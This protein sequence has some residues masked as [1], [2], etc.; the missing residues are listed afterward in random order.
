MVVSCSNEETIFNQQERDYNVE[1]QLR[2]PEEALAIAEEAQQLFGFDSRTNKSVSISDICI[3][4]CMNMSK[5][6][7]N[8][9]AIYAVNFGDD[10]GFALIAASRACEKPL[11]GITDS[12]NYPSATEPMNNFSYFLNSARTYAITPTPKDSIIYGDQGLY[13]V[14][15]LIPITTSVF[16]TINLGQNWPENMYCPNK[17][18]GCA[19]VAIAEMLSFFE[20]LNS[21]SLTY[22]NRD[23]DSIIIDWENLKV[24]RMS[25]DLKNPTDAQIREH[26][27]GCDASLDDH[28]TIG[29]FIRQLGEIQ[30]SRYL[31]DI[32][33]TGTS[34]YFDAAKDLVKSDLICTDGTG[35]RSLHDRFIAKGKT[36]P[37]IALL[38]GQSNEGGHGWIADGYSY[39][40]KRIEYFRK[41]TN[42]LVLVV[43]KID[44]YLHFNW[45]WAGK[46]NG[47]FL[48]DALNPSKEYD[49]WYR[50]IENGAPDYEYSTGVEYLFIEK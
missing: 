15:T 43:E 23:Q 7:V 44:R 11:I 31:Y 50:P 41:S 26:L 18:A 8:D 25:T 3:I 39:S 38:C 45:G 27:I 4:P 48:I 29:R 49:E 36:E 13:E 40:G 37:C 46:Y 9:T 30:H 33:Q 32:T 17:I 16:E 19:A 35:A 12:G 24:H 1:S 2:S 14:T 20:V 5:S 34:D 47:F 22:P 42:E 21:M 28:K 6:G 10:K